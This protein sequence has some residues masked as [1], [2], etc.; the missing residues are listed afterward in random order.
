MHVFVT[1]IAPLELK[2]ADIDFNGN[3]TKILARMNI[4][5]L[6]IKLKTS[7]DFASSPT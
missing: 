5:L 1:T 3:R 4:G 2:L 6:D 7:Y